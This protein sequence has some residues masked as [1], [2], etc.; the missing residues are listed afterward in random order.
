M[1]T[2]IAKTPIQQKRQFL[3]DLSGSVS[4]KVKEGEFNSINE[5]I[6]AHYRQGEHQEFRTF[7]QWLKDGYAVRK[8]EKAFIVWAKPK[9]VQKVEKTEETDKYEYYPICYLFSNAQVERRS[10]K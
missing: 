5:A 9:E 8:G 6:I 3:K 2:N 4:E 1:S 7:N 10:E